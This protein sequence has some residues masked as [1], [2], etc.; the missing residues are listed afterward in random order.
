MPG[1]S[2][3][4]A[5]PYDPELARQLL[6]EAGYAGGRGFPPVDAFVW[7]QWYADMLEYLQVQWL[8]NLGVEIGRLTVDLET[9]RQKHLEGQ[10]QQ[11]HLFLNGWIADYPDPHNFLSF[12]GLT[13]I[14]RHWGSA[15]Y[16]GL[17]E[18]ARQATDQ[19]ERMVLYQQADSLLVEE[20]VVMPLT[21][22]RSHRLIKPWVARYPITAMG[23]RWWKDVVIEPH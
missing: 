7:T 4:I 5:L 12:W 3:G 18:K 14:Q 21:Y 22:G 8:E 9:Y 6:A 13:G 23:D 17:M 10:K 15:A 20:A 16:E 11:P 1:H 19:A 2:P